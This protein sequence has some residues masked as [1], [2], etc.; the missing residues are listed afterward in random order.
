VRARSARLAAVLIAAFSV[1]VPIGSQTQP[2]EGALR[3][4]SA[5]GTLPSGTTGGL[6]RPEG[7]TAARANS[8]APLARRRPSAPRAPSAPA[9]IPAGGAP[10]AA[11][12]EDASGPSDVGELDPLVSNG[13]ASPTCART[14]LGGLNTASR[15]HCETSGFIA[16]AAPTGDYGIDVHIDT[17]VLGLSGGGLLSAVQDLCVTPVWM[18]LVWA[19]HALVVMLEWCF[20]I[21]LLAGADVGRL[22]VGLRRMEGAFTGPWLPLALACASVLAMYH[23]L[24]RRRVAETAGQAALMAAMMALGLWVILDPAGTV[25]ALGAW[26]NEAATG[27]LATA[28]QGSPARPQQALATGL[29]TVF[30]A[31][32]D[33]P[34]CYLEFG[35]VEWCRMPSRLDR[36]L[37]RAG[38]RIAAQEQALIGCKSS[39]SELSSCVADGSPAAKAL[40]RSAE[41]L[42]SAQTNGEIFLALPANGPARNSINDEGS[43]LRA[44][45]QSPR[46]TSCRGASATQAEFRTN[47]STWSR[48]GGLVLILAGALGMLLLLGFLALRLLAAAIFSLLYLLL[49]P[50]MVL[51]PAFGDGGR[52]A[53]RRWSTQLL[54]MVVAK[55][56]YAFLLGAVL[57]MLAV[58][59]G[60]S[61]VGWWTQWLLMSALWWGAFARRHQLLA[62]E[63][64]A[65]DR[66]RGRLAVGPARG[67]MAAARWARR[68]LA[69][70]RASAPERSGSRPAD[71]GHP[72]IDASAAANAGAPPE[73]GAVPMPVPSEIASRGGERG[74]GHGSERGDPRETE[75]A[76]AG[77]RAQLGRIAKAH[78]QALAA[79]D[80][81]RTARLACRAERVGDELEGLGPAARA[82]SAE[83]IPRRA[84]GAATT[85]RGDAPRGA[86]DAP[87]VRGDPASE[88]QHPQPRRT[89]VGQ[90]PAGARADLDRELAR[91]RD[92]LALRHGSDVVPRR[93]LRDGSSQEPSARNAPGP[94]GLASPPGSDPIPRRQAPESSVMRDLREVEAGRKRQLGRGRP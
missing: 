83:A 81:R 63:A 82:A 66:R 32:V 88:R 22:G 43:L 42:R 86:R 78:G 64:P 47:G 9:L 59:S 93:P 56:L 6:R 36:S 77:K 1:T 23:G 45:C 54:G 61:A 65:G 72:A 74:G 13:L 46:A 94:D 80:T 55:L 44:I 12:G 27:T 50:L 35:D 51:A 10:G 76:L 69:R 75:S 68:R 79:G 3:G 18:A 70:E 16:A 60:L 90:S 92:Q 73:R 14:D 29:E 2:A 8:P 17:G 25:G 24:I 19:V 57:A 31:A 30:A 26:A 34:W 89:A 48:I 71:R 38:L 58:I 41:L 62:F 11:G 7:A 20:T 87:G 84:S 49:A 40:R 15:R 53:F 4:G 37:R 52:A 39:A 5:G 33:A 67:S 85:G 91:R 28:A 21:D